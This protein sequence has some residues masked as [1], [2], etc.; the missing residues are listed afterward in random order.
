MTVTDTFRVADDRVGVAGILL[1][2]TP[3]RLRVGFDGPDGSWFMS[4]KGGSLAPFQ[5]IQLQIG[6]APPDTRP[7]FTEVRMAARIGHRI[8]GDLPFEEMMALLEES[9]V[10]S[11][12]EMFGAQIHLDAGG[13][14]DW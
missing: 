6:D 8:L 2:G 3:V 11:V 10:P 14:K 13:G 5:V 1:D 12:R 7:P 4:A 9:C